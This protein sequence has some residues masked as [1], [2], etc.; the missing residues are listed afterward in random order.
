MKAHEK[1]GIAPSQDDASMTGVGG[2]KDSWQCVLVEA[3][4]GA[5]KDKLDK[6]CTSVVASGA[7][8]PYPLAQC[9]RL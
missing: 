8:A 1:R 2:T 7:T 5:G 3:F 6:I 4:W 9:A